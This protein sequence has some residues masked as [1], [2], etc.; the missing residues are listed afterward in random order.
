MTRSGWAALAGGT[1][2]YLV[3]WWMGS[4]EIAVFA[5]A[6]LVLVA[7]S[8]LFLLRRPHLTVERRISSPRVQVGEVAE[9]F[10]TATN[11]ASHRAGGTTCRDHVAGVASEIALPALGPGRSVTIPYPLPTD[12]RRVLPIGPL[13]LVVGDP[14]GLAERRTPVAGDAVLHVHPRVHPVPGPKVGV[15]VD[16]DA[17]REATIRGD[18]TFHSLREYVR[19][20]DLRRVHW[21]ATA[22]VGELM[23]REQVDPVRPD[24]TLV[25]DGRRTVLDAD[26]FE[27][28][29]EVV[30]SIAVAAADRGLPVRLAGTEPGLRDPIGGDDRGRLL[31]RLAGVD[32]HDPDEGL[33]APLGRVLQAGGGRSLVVVTGR[34]S[35]QDLSALAVHGRRF[36]EIVVV[37]VDP[38]GEVPAAPS[39]VEVVA[40]ADAEGFVAAWGR[41]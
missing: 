10:V 2:A 33:V 5:I 12:R 41:R 35:A 17:E 18:A 27:L 23:V 19:G 22:H 3:A 21:K 37:A 36:Q 11:E 15:R 7:V 1:I 39:R 32:R 25:L 8:L 16:L 40:V 31:D 24:T 34:P 38:A 13:E 20:D 9:A 28:A 30:A 14:F 29:V 26:G 4:P 6:V